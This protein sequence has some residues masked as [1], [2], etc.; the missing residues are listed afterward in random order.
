[1]SY[2]NYKDWGRDMVKR[3]IPLT[4]HGSICEHN[5]PAECNDHLHLREF[6]LGTY[7][8]VE[9]G[10]WKVVLPELSIRLGFEWFKEVYL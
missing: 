2:G 10:Y 1:M 8:C 4:L 5:C 6:T 9:C 7:E 3:G